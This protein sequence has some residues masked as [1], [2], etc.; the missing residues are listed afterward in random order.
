MDQRAP[1]TVGF[2]LIC[3]DTIA[4]SAVVATVGAVNM[5]RSPLFASQTELTVPNNQTWIIWDIYI[6]VAAGAGTSDPMVSI[7]K[8]NDREMVLTPNLST[9]LVSNNYRPKFSAM[10]IGYAPVD[11]LTMLLETTI[12]NDTVADSIDFRVAV[13]VS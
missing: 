12:A 4:A 2:T 3:T 10:N 8:N 5:Q 9:L 13:R 7:Q 6:V 11:I 1:N